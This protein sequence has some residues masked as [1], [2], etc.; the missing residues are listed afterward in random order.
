FPLAY[1]ENALGELPNPRFLP[2]SMFYPLILLKE[3]IMLFSSSILDRHL[4]QLDLSGKRL[5]EAYLLTQ[6]GNTKLANRTMA[7]Y[8]KEI[9]TALN[10][11]NEKLKSNLVQDSEMVILKRIFA[12]HGILLEE[13]GDKPIIENLKHRLSKMG[14]IPYYDL[15]ENLGMSKYGRKV[16]RFD[17][18]KKGEYEILLKSL[19]NRSFYK[20]NLDI[21]VLQID[22]Q[23]KMFTSSQEGDYLSL[24]KVIL[25]VGLHEIS[26]NM[27]DSVNL[28][29]DI[30]SDSFKTTGS[31]II[32]S[33]N[34]EPTFVF[35][36]TKQ[37]SSTLSF[38]ITGFDNRSIYRVNFDFWIQS[39]QGPILQFEQNSD[40]DIKGER[41]MDVN[42]LFDKGNY[43]FYWNSASASINP[44][45]NTAEA[46]LKITGE[47]WNNC[48]EILKDKNICLDKNANKV[49]NR[50]SSFAVKNI[51]VKRLLTDD[52]ILR[53]PKTETATAL[54]NNI[55]LNQISPS[56][57]EGELTLDR[58]VSLSLLTTFHPE[59][60]LYLIKDGKTNLVSE[61]R[62]FLLN[63]Y[64]NL[65]YLNE[66]PGE[67]KIKIEF[68]PQKR[69]YQ[70]IIVSIVG[71]MILIVI[72]FKYYRR[73]NV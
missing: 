54:L 23:V 39:G 48:F 7:D 42:K 72:S 46:L 4:V 15:R 8:V 53:S 1:K 24:N 34:D 59:W 30:N 22:N 21:I 71:T 51:S 61:D 28:V 60:K 64:G 44:R 13:L 73:K 52:I 45:I 47:P 69:F 38:P 65:W 50:E 18:K 66:S 3:K 17:I 2:G 57:Y 49:F 62:H 10:L 31:V 16:Y 43:N 11:I 63:G 35:N 41:F 33:K 6:K 37:E 14:F 70:G 29:P 68:L 36:T 20:D 25:D 12:R 32:N 9:N 55:N 58:P 40:W 67:Y 5:A 26:Y 19:E 56:L 27:I